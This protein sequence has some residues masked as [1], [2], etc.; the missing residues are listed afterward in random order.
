MEEEK[1]VIKITNKSPREQQESKNKTFGYWY[2]VDKERFYNLL[3]FLEKYAAENNLLFFLAVE[4]FRGS[5]HFYILLFHR[6][7]LPL[8]FKKVLKRH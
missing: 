5:N 7:T 2:L 1:K 3:W 8:H 4:H 6:T